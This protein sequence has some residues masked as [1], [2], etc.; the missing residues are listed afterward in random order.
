MASHPC[1][2]ALALVAG[3]AQVQAAT[4]APDWSALAQGDLQFAIDTIRSSHAGAVAGQAD[5][6]APLAA[7]ARNGMQ[8]AAAAAGES[9]YL[10]TLMRFVSGFGDPHTSVN[11]QLKTRAWTGIMLDRVGGEFRV[12]WSEP[13]WAQPLP[14][15]NA[16]AQSCNGVWIGT[17]L[18]TNVA[19]FSNRSLEYASSLGVHAR[20]VMFDLGLGWTPSHCTF[21]LP[22]GSR[23]S[24]ALPLQ[25]V[26]GDAG[27]QHLAQVQK[28]TGVK[29][30]PVGIEKLAAGMHWVGMPDFN[31]ATSGAAYEK[32]YPQLAALRMDGWI[33]FD[34]RGNGGGDSSWGSRALAA[35]Y[36]SA[37]AEKLG[38]TAV[39][40]KQLIATPATVALYRDYASKPEYAASRDEMARALARLEAA[41]EAGK[42][43]AE[44]CGSSEAEAAARKAAV[45]RHPGRLRVAAVINRSC[46]SSCMAFLQRIRALDDALVLGE[47]TVGYSPYGEINRFALPSGRGAL[48]IPSALY[49]STQATREPFAPDIAYPGNMGDDAA[50]MKWV[51]AT[52]RKR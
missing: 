11:L 33:V 36:G 51:Q 15:V 8:E 28:Q 21:T 16:V 47:A 48:G 25:P 38:G 31:G 6:T 35:L 37:Y 14:P 24:Y 41:M 2:L 50:L 3:S 40:G 12:V 29:A 10:R 43:M 52:L 22:D 34:L 46:F 20:Q 5:V 13:G 44:L 17:Y 30:R 19:P 45:P 9:D 32:L 4:P 26:D 39:Y 1:L 49:L 18:K 42:P 7:G 23:R 27:T